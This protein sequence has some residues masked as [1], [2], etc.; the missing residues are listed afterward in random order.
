MTLE[1]RGQI[2]L[3]NF[4]E[5]NSKFDNNFTQPSMDDNRFEIKKSEAHILS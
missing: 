4:S 2:V 1:N 3:K 5:A